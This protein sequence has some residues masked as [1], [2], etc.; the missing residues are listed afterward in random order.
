MDNKTVNWRK[1]LVWS[2]STEILEADEKRDRLEEKRNSLCF[3]SSYA[4]DD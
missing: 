3:A 4:S 1:I 2:R